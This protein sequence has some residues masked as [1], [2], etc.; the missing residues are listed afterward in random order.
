MYDYQNDTILL[1]RD[2]NYF[3]AVGQA[4]CIHEL[5]HAIMDDRKIP[6]PTTSR[7]EAIAYLGEAFYLMRRFNMAFGRPSV[8]IP[9]IYAQTQPL[10]DAVLS[11]VKQKPE[12]IRALQREVLRLGYEPLTSTIHD[13]IW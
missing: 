6:I 8:N 2:I 9:S 1:R 10:I 12:D 11:G 13:G 5:T 3:T 7:D 4:K